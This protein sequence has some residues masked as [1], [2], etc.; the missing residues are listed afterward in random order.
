MTRLYQLVAE[1]RKTGKETDIG[2]PDTHERIMR[3]KQAHLGGNS[4]RVNFY[5]IREEK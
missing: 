3:F 5:K 1:N 2:K 4:E